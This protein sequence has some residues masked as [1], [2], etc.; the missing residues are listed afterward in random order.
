MLEEIPAEMLK[1]QLLSI[2]GIARRKFV[3]KNPTDTAKA[4]RDLVGVLFNHHEFV[5][6]R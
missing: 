4:R 5:T 1:S 2:Q 6:V 3:G